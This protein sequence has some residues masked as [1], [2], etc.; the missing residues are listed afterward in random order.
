MVFFKVENSYLLFFVKFMIW[1]R[2]FLNSTIVVKCEIWAVHIKDST[3]V[4]FMILAPRSSDSTIVES[5]VSPCK[6][7]ICLHHYR[8]PIR[9]WENF[10][11]FVIVTHFRFHRQKFKI[12]SIS[13]YFYRNCP[14]IMKILKI[15]VTAD[16]IIVPT[17]FANMFWVIRK[18]L[19]TWK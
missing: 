19:I 8:W 16:L 4:K 1:A 2:K 10:T 13:N 14:V 5:V 12:T 17:G 15:S 11:N 3:I 9:A 18:L 6:P 7:M